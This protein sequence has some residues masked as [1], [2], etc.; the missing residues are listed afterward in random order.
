MDAVSRR[1]CAM[2][3]QFPAATSWA[4]LIARETNAKITAARNEPTATMYSIVLDVFIIEIAGGHD[5]P[6]PM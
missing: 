5:G 6:Q 2:T 4:S 3:V 1:N